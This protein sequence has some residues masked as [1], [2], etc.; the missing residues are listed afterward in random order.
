MHERL[1]F[2]G[3]RVLAIDFLGCAVFGD[4]GQK[5]VDDLRLGIEQNRINP[6]QPVLGNGQ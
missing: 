2:A 6:V 3:S 5:I 1:E 4:H